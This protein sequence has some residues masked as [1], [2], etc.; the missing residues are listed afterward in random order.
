[1]AQAGET[2]DG[3]KDIIRGW[4]HVRPEL[5]VSALEVFG[6]L[7][8]SYLLYRQEINAGFEAFG[9]HEAGFDVLAALRRSEP[10]HRCTAGELARQTLVT[11]GGLTLRVNRLEAAGLV[12]RVR[13]ADDARV[14]YVA[15][16]EAGR[17][18]V[19]EIADAHFTK[20]QRMLAP[21]D[22]DTRARLA[23]LLSELEDSLQ[24]ATDPGDI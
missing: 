19:D 9:I 5:D 1:M 20:L 13:D 17:K 15:L 12:T 14:V 10:D 7:H 18:L 21:L 23:D 24:V 16:T 6:R 8:R 3:V 2:P 22:A 11:T 4:A